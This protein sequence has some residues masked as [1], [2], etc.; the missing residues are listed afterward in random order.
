MLERTKFQI[1]KSKKQS[2]NQK[3]SNKVLPST[4]ILVLMK[5]KWDF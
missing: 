4:T 5:L 1:L 2:E 3:S